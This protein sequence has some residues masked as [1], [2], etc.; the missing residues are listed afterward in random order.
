[1]SLKFERPPYILVH[2][3]DMNG[4]GFHRVIR[5]VEVLSKH[6]YISARAEM[7]FV[8]EHILPHLDPDVVIFQRQ[9]D[10]NQYQAMVRYRE[11]LPNAFFIYEIDDILSAIPDAS[12]H[13]PFMTP[14]ID[15]RLARAAS[16]CDVITVTTQ[17][18]ADHMR[19]LCPDTPIR[20]VP[21]L[22]A[23]EDLDRAAAA[24]KAPMQPASNAPGRLRIGWGGGMGH[25]G[26]LALLYEAMS[27][28]RDE[29]EWVFVG[30]EP[31]N[32]PEGT[33]YSFAGAAPP[34]QYLQL[35]AVT[36]VD[37]IVAPLEQN[38][39]NRCK[40]NLRLVEA[41]ACGFP[42]IATTIAP[43][44]THRPPVYAYADTAEDWV[45]KIRRF[46]AL[47]KQGRKQHAD[48]M[49]Q[50]VER[51]YVL[52]SQLVERTKMWLPDGAAHF[53]PRAKID[54]RGVTV[55][56]TKD[57][58]IA[59]CALSGHDVTYVRPGLS[60]DDETLERL[61]KNAA[62]SKVATCSV[63]TNDGGPAGFPQPNQFSALPTGYGEQLA[64]LCQG[65]SDLISMSAAVG[66]VVVLRRQALEMIGQ[67]DFA[68][69]GEPE[70][71]ILEWSIIAAARGF[72]NVVDTRTFIPVTQTL[73]STNDAVQQVSMRVSAR[74][75]LQKADDDS[76]A[77]FRQELEL[78]FFH[79]NYRAPL[80][81][82]RTDYM[83]WVRANDGMGPRS[84]QKCYEWFASEDRP[85]IDIIQYGSEP[86]TDEVLW[87][88]E[89][90][91]KIFMPKDSIPSMVLMPAVVDAI[92]NYPEAE[93]FYGDHD[94]HTRGVRSGHDF[95]PNF[96][97]HLLLSRD[98]V[99]QIMVVKSSLIKTYVQGLPIDPASTQLHALAYETAFHHGP[100]TVQHIP[101]IL[102]H[103]PSEYLTSMGATARG[104][105]ERLTEFAHDEVSWPITAKQHPNYKGYHEVSYL[106][107]ADRPLVSIIIPTKNKVDMLGPCL[108]TLLSTTKYRNF[109]VLVV[110]NGSDSPDMLDF[111]MDDDST[112][113]PRVSV[114]RWPETYN[115]SKLNNWA[116]RQVDGEVLLFLND[117]TRI[118]EPHWL[119]EMVGAAYFPG[120]AAV[121]AKLVY[122]HGA[123]Q[124]V[125]V[126]NEG[127]L[128]GHM[129]KGMPGHLP[130]YNGIAVLSHEATAVTGACMAIRRE[131]YDELGGF[132]EAL[133]HNYN[134]VAFCLEAIRRGYC[135]VVAARAVLQHLEGVT[136]TSP[137][138]PEGQAIMQG[139]AHYLATHYREPDR[140][141]NP[142]L[143][144]ASVQGG[145]LIGELNMDTFSWPAPAYP[146][147][148]N[149]F[150]RIL[151]LGSTA[152]I[153]N[154]VRDRSAIYRLMLQGTI[155]QIVEPTMPNVRPFDIRDPDSAV[156]AIEQ[157]GID[158]VIITSLDQ[159]TTLA[160][161][162]L[163]RLS[164]PV[165]YRPVSAE[166]VCP[167]RDLRVGESMCN[168]GWKNDACQ[169]CVDINGSPS[170]YVSMDA[171]KAEWT[172]FLKRSNVTVQLDFVEQPQFASAVEHVYG[173][174]PVEEL[175]AS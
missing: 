151:V 18:L 108:A 37:L 23:R 96:D 30:Y 78:K 44:L 46:A 12:Y 140:Y 4:C 110:D 118:T 94:Y 65:M 26:D 73:D 88:N 59:L 61:G 173:A 175:S 117:D 43:Y 11:Q 77:K 39:F 127:G 120:V 134:D 35:L 97:L 139:E 51:R 124:H 52:D 149:S 2:P 109:Q 82:S 49:R 83:A 57:D 107:P 162:F 146:W 114:L 19:S 1:M 42:V 25:A 165:I 169:M 101:R 133:V 132:N 69:W 58:L 22:L 130:G 68:R 163:T 93:I 128:N 21:N 152:N 142:N 7:N 143:M 29:V 148:D 174:A 87:A 6:G 150:E 121:G 72:S 136:R 172:R 53:F 66:P 170:G 84:M 159:G 95:K 90:E 158:R 135:N 45:L 34:N 112:N 147:A 99:S 36:Q 48:A 9:N 98:Y 105:A 60:V 171:W 31:P 125:G 160:L 104:K 129:H 27:A 157:L 81:E 80:P 33:V 100:D 155:A 47:S 116:A 10:D 75:P 62:D 166:S 13:K 164:I 92:A 56:H 70:I 86:L 54:A 113:D 154:E 38:Q 74:W 141:W 89:S 103:L 85:T 63:F 5:P 153:I 167:R 41:G 168:E 161:S 50:W 24:Q 91:W 15:R 16:L 138:T 67:P 17:D 144:F 145:A 8:P 3:G 106:P 20:I 123:I 55:A 79:D 102:A 115:W 71:A 32:I 119:D 137:L 28:L 122:P 156:R 14:D 40:S 111:L 64:A 126:V 131:V 76:L